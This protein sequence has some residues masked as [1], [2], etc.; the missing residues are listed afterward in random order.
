MQTDM[1]CGMAIASLG[2]NIVCNDMDL[3]E[4]LRQR[5]HNFS[6]ATPNPLEVRVTLH[7]MTE[8][9]APLL[10]CKISSIGE[11]CIST[12]RRIRG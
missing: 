9:S 7:G 3:A 2:V 10:N 1:I 11:F 6:S 4:A 8:E 5:Y 12:A